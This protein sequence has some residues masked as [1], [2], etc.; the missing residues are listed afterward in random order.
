MEEA[1]TD[2]RIHSDI[3]DLVPL[4]NEM[5]WSSENYLIISTQLFS[6][7][8]PSAYVTVLFYNLQ[9]S[10]ITA[11]EFAWNLMFSLVRTL[12]GAVSRVSYNIRLHCITP[13]L[14]T[15]NFSFYLCKGERQDRSEL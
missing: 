12:A 10:G 3:S 2:E 6:T 9:F 7:L 15:G 4:R 14:N 5:G 1:A 8:R 13:L 11:V